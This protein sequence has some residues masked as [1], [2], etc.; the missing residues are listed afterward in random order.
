MAVSGNGLSYFNVVKPSRRLLSAVG[1]E[2][3]MVDNPRF[4]T[5]TLLDL[6]HDIADPLQNKVRAFPRK[7]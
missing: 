6:V 5:R 4:G 1:P 7:L 3:I 2:P